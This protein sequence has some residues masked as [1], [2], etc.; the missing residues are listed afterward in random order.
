MRLTELT[1]LTVLRRLAA[2]GLG[3]PL[4]LEDA[5]A[6]PMHGHQVA[7]FLIPEGAVPVRVV[8]VEPARVEQPATVGAHEALADQRLVALPV[9]ART[10]PPA[11]VLVGRPTR[12]A[13]ADLYEAVTVAIEERRLEG[14]RALNV[15][16]A[17]Q[18]TIGC[19]GD[20]SRLP[21]PP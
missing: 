17:Q 8:Q 6:A 3:A 12:R 9:V 19:T 10:A 15:K 14:R 5:M 11:S 2:A 4:V 1:K 18:E 16:H 21:G 7:R 13:M 20:S